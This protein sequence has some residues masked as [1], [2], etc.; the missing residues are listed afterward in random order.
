M[1][2]VLTEVGIYYKLF[3]I[4]WLFLACE[5]NPDG[6]VDNNCE[7]TTGQCTCKPHIVGEKCDESEPGYHNFPDPKGIRL[8]KETSS[9]IEIIT[10]LFNSMWMQCWRIWKYWMCRIDWKVHMQTTAYHWRQM[11]WMCSW[12]LWIPRLPR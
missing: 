12:I 1:K 10:F 9:L 7:A 4:S 11:Y 5:C 3:D 8:E 2:N 6:S